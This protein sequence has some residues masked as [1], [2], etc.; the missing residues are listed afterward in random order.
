MT[1]RSL[2]LLGVA[3]GHFALGDAGTSAAILESLQPF[4]QPAG[5]NQAGWGLCLFFWLQTNSGLEESPES[6]RNTIVLT[7]PTS[8]ELPSFKN[9]PV[10]E[11]ICGVMFQPLVGLFAPH[12]GLLWD[13]FREEYPNCREA[14]PLVPVL[15][16]FE[17]E[18]SREPDL[19][20][21]F[22]PRIWFVSKDDNAVIQVQ[23][24][25]FL[26]NWRKVRPTD[27]YPRYGVVKNCFQERCERF[28]TF[29]IENQLG[30]I[31]PTQLEL[32]YLNHI[33]IGGGW[34]SIQEVGKVFP[35]FLWR[36]GQRFLGPPEKLHW[37][38][39]FLLP[40]RRGRLHLSIQSALRRQDRVPVFILELTVR[41]I[42]PDR[43]LAGCWPW[44]DEAR[45]WIVRGFADITGREIQQNTWKR[46]A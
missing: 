46:T 4:P 34:D 28:E 40:E 42:G 30:S 33:P 39:S 20:V 15:E 44:F 29:L 3:S 5:L 27:Q 22:L 10:N 17:G 31:N 11:V 2:G 8:V 32:T 19:S 38:T 24:D 6:A 21:P 9:P 37:R 1:P 13:T 26:H 25:R 12:L 36:T 7:E 41:G 43:T 18:E 35:D 23:R 45:N 16:T 14:D